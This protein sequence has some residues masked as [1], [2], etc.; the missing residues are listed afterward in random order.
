MAPPNAC[1]CCPPSAFSPPISCSNTLAKCPP[2][3]PNPRASRLQSVRTQC[4]HKHLP[5]A[6]G[7]ALLVPQHGSFCCMYESSAVFIDTHTRHVRCECCSKQVPHRALS[8]VV[9]ACSHAADVPNPRAS[10]LQ[11]MRTQCRHKHLPKA[12]GQALLVPQHGSCC[13]MYV[14]SA[15]F[16]DTHTRHV[17]CEC[18][19]K[20]VPHRVLSCVVH[21]CSHAADVPNPRATML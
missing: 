19:S 12:P 2:L 4:R 15:V 21:A 6:P 1:E 13:C 17:R 11:S 20:Q 16:I 3:V 18:S 7:Q 14:S 5:K 8:C 9:H 10:R